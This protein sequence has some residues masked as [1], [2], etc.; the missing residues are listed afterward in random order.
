[1]AARA[2]GRRENMYTIPRTSSL[3]TV[4]EISSALDGVTLGSMEACA[5]IHAQTR[6]SAYEIFLLDPKSGRA[7]VRGGESFTEPM[8]VIVNGS[9]F[10][11]CMLKAGWLGVGLQMEFF[12]NGQR[13]VTSPV[14]SLRVEHVGNL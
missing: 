10:G 4:A 14:Q 2:A 7:L 9:T 13:T 8:E 3:E 11:G 6:N 1:M 5:I 12:A